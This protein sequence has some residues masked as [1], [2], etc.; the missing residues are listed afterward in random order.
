MRQLQAIKTLQFVSGQLWLEALHPAL[1]AVAPLGPYLVQLLK[2][3]PALARDVPFLQL[4]QQEAH[5]Q[6]HMPQGSSNA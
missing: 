3:A 1:S 2:G 4:A 6:Q 5:L